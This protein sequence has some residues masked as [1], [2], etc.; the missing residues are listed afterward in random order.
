[1]ADNEISLETAIQNGFEDCTAEDL[2][3]FCQ[4]YNIPVTTRMRKNVP[5][6]KA[7]ILS[8]FADVVSLQ[9]GEVQK[10]SPGEMAKINPRNLTPNGGMQWG[11]IWYTVEIYRDA[12][13]KLTA[14][15]S[16]KWGSFEIFVP[17]G[18]VV[19]IPYPHYEILQNAEIER[20]SCGADPDKPWQIK[21]TSDIVQYLPFRDY[22]PTKGTENRPKSLLEFYHGKGQKWFDGLNDRNIMKLYAS[23][24]YGLRHGGDNRPPNPFNEPE[25]IREFLSVRFEYSDP[26]AGDQ[27][28]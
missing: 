19:S 17:L 5:M 11:G 15:R 2:N 6:L 23:L 14:P 8:K 13:Q 27:L 22:G 10:L 20:L 12:S 9:H 21:R 26:A 1:M 18:K 3:R 24:G 28:L 7:A 16:L 25:N 4:L